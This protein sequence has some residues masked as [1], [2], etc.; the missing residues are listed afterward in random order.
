MTTRR[1]LLASAAAASLAPALASSLARAQSLAS[2]PTPMGV[3]MDRLAQSQLDRS[4]VTTTSLGLD[5]G[6]RAGAKSLLDDASLQ[7]REDDKALASQRLAELHA[8]PKASITGADA[9]HYA[10][11]DDVFTRTVAANARFGY[12]DGASSP[13]AVNQLS[14][15]YLDIP[16]FLDSAHRI[17]TAEDCHAYLARLNAY[18]TAIDQ[19]GERTHHDAALSVFAPGFAVDKVLQQTRIQRDTPIAEQQLIQSLVRRAKEKGIAGDWA[20]PATA[21]YRQSVLPALDRQIAQFTELRK[22]ASTDAGVWRLPDGPALYAAALRAQTTSTLSPAEVHKLG[23]QIVAELNAK[24]DAVFRSQRMTQGTSGARLR[25]LFADPRFVAP[26]TD[27]GKA[28]LIADCNARVQQIQAKLP[29]YFGVLPKAPVEIRRIPAASEV[30]ASTHYQSASLDGSRPGIYWLNLRDTAETPTWDLWTTTYHEA[31]PGHHLQISI[32]QEAAL[33]LA[34]KMMGFGAY[35]EGW[36]LY[37]EELAANEMDMY[38]GD[39]FGRVGY[40]HD[41]LLRA[42]RL[43]IDTGLHDQ[44]WTR[45]RAIAYFSA[46]LGD[47]EAMAVSEVE[48]YCVGPGQACS[49]M[50]GKI[51]WLRARAAAKAR[52]GAKFDIRRFHDAGLTSGSM[53]L[54]VLEKVLG[55]YA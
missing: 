12:G 26:N 25:A 16:E 33:P 42:V 30:S 40:L 8:I 10:I 36:A 41:A 37:A 32:Q 21:I 31:I 47:P 43:V 38:A 35:V 7:R 49:Y 53:P 18:A 3:W 6:A 50:V 39:P 13:Y 34:R 2:A 44:R 29:T 48:R 1:A 5:T 19:D 17:E 45:E 55:S 46:N 20:T 52:L 14:G 24:L 15:A 11:F 28:K 22:T 27:A 9:T 51:T 4:P 23:L 54:S